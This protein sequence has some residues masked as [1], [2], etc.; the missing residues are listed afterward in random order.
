MK[1][2]RL[3]GLVS[4]PYHLAGNVTTMVAFDV[5]FD[6]HRPTSPFLLQHRVVQKLCHRRCRPVV[7][8]NTRKMRLL[9]GRG[10]AVA[11]AHC[12]A[13]GAVSPA[14]RSGFRGSWGVWG[15]A[16]R[17]TRP[18]L[19]LFLLA[20]EAFAGLLV[21]PKCPH[22]RA[23]LAAALYKPASQLSFLGQLSSVPVQM[24][25]NSGVAQSADR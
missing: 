14:A 22:A 16:A 7:R 20:D 1:Q 8:K 15:A 3:K 2:F 11:T 12:L 19:W 10:K 9:L 4:F 21:P 5:R 25:R 24:A 13:P 6:D 18:R 17:Q 23:A